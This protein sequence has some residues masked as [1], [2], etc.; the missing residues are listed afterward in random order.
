M[1]RLPTLQGASVCT[2][3]KTYKAKEWLTA[4]LSSA[5]ATFAPHPKKSKIL[6]SAPATARFFVKII[7]LFHRNK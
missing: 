2:L 3:S 4:V 6:L 5:S 7:K 1:C